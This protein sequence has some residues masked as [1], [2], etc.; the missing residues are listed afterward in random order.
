MFAAT[1]RLVVRGHSPEAAARSFAEMAKRLD[2]MG[3]CLQR[4]DYRHLEM[5]QACA[6]GL[7][8]TSNDQARL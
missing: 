7:S 5:W 1:I 3:M 4:S 8:G 2:R 6:V